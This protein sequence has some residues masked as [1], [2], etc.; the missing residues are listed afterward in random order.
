MEPLQGIKPVFN[1]ERG[2]FT[3]VNFSSNQFIV[4]SLY[5]CRIGIFEL[6]L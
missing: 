5:V 6:I 1:V 4:L 2:N 3:F